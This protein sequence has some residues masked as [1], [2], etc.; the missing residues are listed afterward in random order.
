VGPAAAGR[1]ERLAIVLPFFNEEGSVAWVLE[2]IRDLY[3]RAEIIAVDDGSSD[4]TW[5]RMRQV[6]GV[7]AL[8]LGAN[9]GQSAAIYA[10]LRAATR[11]LSALMDGDGQNDPADIGRLIEALGDADVACG[12]RADRQDNLSK[13]VASRIANAVRRTLL[14]DG[15]R[16]TGCSLK[17]FARDHVE[18][19]VPFDG[20]HRYLPAL[21]IAAGLRLVEVPV[22]HRPRRY[23]E[24][25]YTNLSRA[26][27]GLYDL[28]GVRWL[29]RRKIRFPKIETV[30]E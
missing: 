20:M 13:R 28:V 30:D 5:T 9:R 3:P 21:F 14:D 1:G 19:L 22:N 6:P 18:Q 24:S 26:L 29:L 15:V 23:G 25:K 16:D 27:R 7:V 17:V 2:E 4:E 10:G 11:P 12:Y 8:R